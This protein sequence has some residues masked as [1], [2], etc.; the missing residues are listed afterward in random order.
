M[1]PDL[2]REGRHIVTVE[3]HFAL[4]NAFYDSARA[5]SVLFNLW[6]C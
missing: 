5:F 1:W 2:V 4:L 6:L 3:H